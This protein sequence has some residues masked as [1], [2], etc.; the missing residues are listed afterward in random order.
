[1]QTIGASVGAAVL[2]AILQSNASHH[3]GASA[4]AF[5]DTFWWALAAT[6]L[7]LVPALLLSLRRR[8][9]R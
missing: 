9:G 3:V 6:A 1:M 2:A 8:E 4:R 7:T 5:A